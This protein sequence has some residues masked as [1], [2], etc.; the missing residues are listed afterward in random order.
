MLTQQSSNNN[1]FKWSLERGQRV[2]KDL[3]PSFCF[4]P[5]CPPSNSSALPLFIILIQIFI[6]NRFGIFLR[7]SRC[8]PMQQVF[9]H[10]TV[11][12]SIISSFSKLE[13]PFI[14]LDDLKAWESKIKVNTSS[15]F[16][17]IVSQ[18]SFHKGDSKVL[19]K[20]NQ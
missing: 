10:L 5:S 18:M 6:F 7:S 2:N 1:S 17:K 9:S 19:F 8:C 12:N 3:N 11:L 15:Y 4:P 16:F 13:I 14:K 20:L